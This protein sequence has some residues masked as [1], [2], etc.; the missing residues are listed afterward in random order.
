MANKVTPLVVKYKKMK[1]IRRIDLG[2][3]F[4][5]KKILIKNNCKVLYSAFKGESLHVWTIE[6]SDE[7]DV[8]AEFI[9]LQRHDEV[10]D[11]YIYIDSTVFGNNFC[12]HIFMKDE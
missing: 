7:E 11:N 10:K 2:D 5:K 12:V 3:D 8:L 6:D 9:I 1:K 4:S